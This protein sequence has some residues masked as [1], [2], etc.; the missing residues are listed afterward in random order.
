MSFLTGQVRICERNPHVVSLENHLV[1]LSLRHRI[2][3][4]GNSIHMSLSQLLSVD[5]SAF[6]R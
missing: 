5:E 6:L 4:G 2:C 1:G 3:F